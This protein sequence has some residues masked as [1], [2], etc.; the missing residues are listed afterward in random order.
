M[1][2]PVEFEMEHDFR[3]YIIFETAPFEIY[4]RYSADR[5]FSCRCY[6]PAPT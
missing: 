4:F 5:I 2:G 6:P 1:N 3:T